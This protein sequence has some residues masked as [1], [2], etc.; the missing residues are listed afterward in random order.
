M[1]DHAAVPGSIEGDVRRGI[2]ARRAH[3]PCTGSRTARSCPTLDL[4]LRDDIEEGPRLT[5]GTK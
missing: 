3:S 4:A 5:V 1:H 2:T